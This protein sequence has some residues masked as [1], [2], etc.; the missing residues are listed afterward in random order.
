VLQTLECIKA[1]HF[2]RENTKKFLWK[3]TA[4]SQTHL[5]VEGIPPPQTS[6][7]RCLWRLHSSAEGTGTPTTFL[8]TGLRT[9]VIN[10][11]VYLNCTFLASHV[12]LFLCIRVF[13]SRNFSPLLAFQVSQFLPLQFGAIFHVS[14]N[15]IID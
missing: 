13:I 7:R 14:H 1:H 4:P 3:G 5:T 10:C 2:E 6:P 12:R 15:C 8:A 11:S 9:D